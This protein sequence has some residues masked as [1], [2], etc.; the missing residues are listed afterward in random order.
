MCARSKLHAFNFMDPPEWQRTGMAGCVGY[1]CP[2]LGIKKYLKHVQHQSSS[3]VIFK[4]CHISRLNINHIPTVDGLC[5]DSKVHGKHEHVQ[6]NFTS[7]PF[8]RKKYLI[9]IVFPIA[10]RSRKKVMKCCQAIIISVPYHGG[11]RIKQINAWYLNTL[12]VYL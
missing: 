2:C 1:S 11:G 7:L 12:M 6:L 8:L 4:Y 5:V 9:F 3:Y 10:K